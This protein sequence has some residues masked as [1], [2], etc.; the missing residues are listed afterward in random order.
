MN[1]ETDLLSVHIAKCLH[2]CLI[3]RLP[4]NHGTSSRVGMASPL[5]S[6]H[7]RGKYSNYCNAGVPFITARRNFQSHFPVCSFPARCVRFRI[8]QHIMTDASQEKLGS[9]QVLV[10]AFHSKTPSISR[11]HTDSKGGCLLYV[12]WVQCAET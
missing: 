9:R 2:F 3:F 12:R 11:L 5:T 10:C 7:L 8:S 4:R 1:Y 6:S